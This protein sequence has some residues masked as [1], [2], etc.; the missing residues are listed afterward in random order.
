MYVAT[1]NCP[2]LTMASH[3]VMGQAVSPQCSAPQWFCLKA[4][5]TSTK[6]Q[7]GWG[8]QGPL[9]PSGPPPLQ[10][11]HPEQDAWG[12][13]RSPGR[14][15]HSLWAACASALS[16]HNAEVLLVFRGIHCITI[17]AHGLLSWHWA[18]FKRAQLHPLC[19]FPLA[20]YRYWWDPPCHLFSRLSSLSSFS[21]SSWERRSSPKS[22]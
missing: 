11:S 22:F 12:C 17:C 1:L 5:R 7:N 3:L 10:Q 15:P 18:P 16:L 8:C 9:C 21:L 19:T 14:R 2:V 6:P 20:M 13:W 4:F